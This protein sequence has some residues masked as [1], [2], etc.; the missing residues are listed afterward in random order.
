MEIQT[1]LAFFKRIQKTNKTK[2]NHLSLI[3]L[4]FV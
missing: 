3:V 2:K 1:D 4:D